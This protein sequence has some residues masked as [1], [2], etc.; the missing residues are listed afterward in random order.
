MLTVEEV[1]DGVDNDIL[2]YDSL[3]RSQKLT[4]SHAEKVQDKIDKLEQHYKNNPAANNFIFKLYEL[5]ALIDY[6]KGNL[7]RA[8][9]FL[10]DARRQMPANGYFTSKTIRELA[11]MDAPS[12]SK[13]QFSGRLEGWLALYGLRIIILPFVL[14]WDIASTG[15]TY[16]VFNDQSV[17]VPSDIQAYITTA[18]VAE[19]IP[20]LATVYI[21]YVFFTKK[22]AAITAIKYFE[23]YLFVAYLVFGVWISSLYDKYQVTDSDDDV[24][25]LAWF[26][27]VAAIWCVYWIRSKRVK[28]T[29][30]Q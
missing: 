27:I 26:A 6:S 28:Q 22:K 20:L 18:V 21:W 17:A 1:F 19:L 9:V 7:P 3:L 8:K 5:Q 11:D 10:D 16:N 30:T 25:K 4:R 29:Y 24:G 23:G 2:E 15:S 13:K 12:K 14:I